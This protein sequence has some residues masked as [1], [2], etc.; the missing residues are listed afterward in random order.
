MVSLAAEALPTPT[1]SKTSIQRGSE[2]I[3]LVDDDGLLR[4]VTCDLLQIAGYRV[5]SAE[6]P[7]EALHL[8]QCH[9]GP[10]DILLTDVSM[11]TMN[12]RELA[13]QLGETWPNMKVL[14]V[15]GYADDILLEG[16]H[17]AL[18]KGL[19]FLQKPYS[20]LALSRR[21]REVLLS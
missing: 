20:L 4:E 3:L 2:T 17:G 7:H 1:P 9:I 11:P 21:I 6:S 8:A 16:S 5:I 14:Y 19:A 10:I 13:A 12:G 18:E 15:S